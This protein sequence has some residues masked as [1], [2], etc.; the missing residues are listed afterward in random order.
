MRGNSRPEAGWFKRI[1]SK[2]VWWLTMRG[3]WK[4]VQ[5]IDPRAWFNC[6][7]RERFGLCPDPVPQQKFFDRAEARRSL[8]LPEDGRLI[9]SVGGQN[10]RKGSDYLLRSFARIVSEEKEYLVFIGRID[11]TIGQLIEEL[12]RENSQFANR[13]IVRNEFVSE[14]EFQQAIIASDIVA[15][16]YRSVSYTHLTL[17]TKR[18]V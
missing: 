15:A 5:L 12:K 2:F 4:R 7:N 9:V 10:K 13:L 18:I 14:D 6:A 8:G 3:P 1:Q 11:E 16:A 17:P